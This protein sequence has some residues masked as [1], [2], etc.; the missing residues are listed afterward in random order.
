MLD[1]VRRAEIAVGKELNINKDLT[2]SQMASL[3]KLLQDSQQAFAW[4]YTKMKGLDPRLCTHKI[5]INSEC[6]LVRQPQ[7]QINPTLKDIVKAELQKLLGVEFIYPIF[8]SQWVSPLGIVPKK[9]GNVEYVQIIE[10]NKVTKKDHFP[11]PL[12]DQVLDNLA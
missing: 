10:L 2:T 4:D 12:I 9:G 8:D 7:R 1:K 11:M 5:F 6:K 3:I